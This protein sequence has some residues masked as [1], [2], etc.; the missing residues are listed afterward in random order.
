[1]LE[2][3]PEARVPAHRAAKTPRG[4]PV[5][6]HLEQADLRGQTGLFAGHAVELC[7]LLVLHRAHHTLAGAQL[8]NR[9]AVL[10][11]ALDPDAGD[12]RGGADERPGSL[13]P[14]A[15]A[16]SGGVGAGGVAG[17]RLPAS[18]ASSSGAVGGR[19]D[20]RR[21]GQRHAERRLAD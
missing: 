18:K 10:A 16:R 15:R 21:H 4:R 6:G 2:A 5:L 19:R 17:G 3:R 14:K 7:R 8:V 9:G 13:V 20:R 1:M 11:E 12:K